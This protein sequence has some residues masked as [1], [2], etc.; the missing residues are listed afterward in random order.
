VCQR[1]QARDPLETATCFFRTV[2]FYHSQKARY[3]DGVLA[4]VSFMNGAK[5]YLRAADTYP[6]DDELHAFYLSCAMDCMRCAGVSIG[7]FNSVAVALRAAVPKMMKIWAF[8]IMQRGGRDE[9]IQA[10]LRSADEMMK[11][12]AEGKLTVEDP[13]PF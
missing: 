9:K 5:A 1:S 11:L 7:D 3:S 6:E 8:S 2:G 13:V 12:V 10:N 4:R